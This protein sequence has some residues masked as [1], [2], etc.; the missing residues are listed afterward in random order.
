MKIKAKVSFCGAFSMSPGE[1]RECNDVAIL[2]DLF[3]AGY[4]EEVRE[5][6]KP[7][8][9]QPAAATKRKR[10]TKKAG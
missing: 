3:R 9:E 2:H 8:P 5:Q 6:K 1:V 7:E 10:T 4:A